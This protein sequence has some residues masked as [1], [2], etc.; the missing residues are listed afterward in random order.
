[1][2]CDRLAWFTEYLEVPGPQEYDP[3][4]FDSMA[5]MNSETWNMGEGDE[6]GLTLHDLLPNVSIVKKYI[7]MA[8]VC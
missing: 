6:R 1:M 8:K 5:V 3:D 2:E 4:A 7:Y